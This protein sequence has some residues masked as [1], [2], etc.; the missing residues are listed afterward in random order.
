L[1]VAARGNGQTFNLPL[2]ITF[3]Q[4][5]P[6]KLT[7]TADFPALKGTASSTFKYK[8]TLRNDSGQ[9]ALVSLNAQAPAGFEVSY[10][11]QYGTQTLA[12][13]PV[14]AGESKTLEA[15]VNLPQG[16]TAGAYKI[17]ALAEAKGVHAETPLDL[18]VE[19][20]PQ[21]S[22]TTP[23]DLLNGEAYAGDQAAI[24][25]VVSNTGSAP[26]RNVKLAS[27]EPSGWTINFEPKTID[28]LAP[29]GEQKVKALITPSAKAIAGDYRVTFRGNSE[30][31][32][33]ST[34]FR[35][36]V[37][38]SSMWGIIGVVVIA[39]SLMVLLLSVIRYGR[40]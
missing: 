9:E 40:R 20:H 2:D 34:D 19:G 22:I 7:L 13:I 32:S 28:L 1:E 3:G 36:T 18:Q 4:A 12:S 27:S 33:N 29:D 21:L 26:A 17:L 11:E 39:I 38:T 15:Q 6:S 10:Q 14:K 35:V 24:D 25:L 5:L 37:R 30:G 16:T 8:L 31:A 23:T